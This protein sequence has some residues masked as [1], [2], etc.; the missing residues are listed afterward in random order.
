MFL[1]CCVAFYTVFCLQELLFLSFRR[2]WALRWS[3]LR[4]VDRL[5]HFACGIYCSVQMNTWHDFPLVLNR[6][7]LHGQKVYYYCDKP[8]SLSHIKVGLC[9]AY[10]STDVIRLVVPCLELMSPFYK[11]ITSYLI[12]PLFGQNSNSH[13][14]HLWKQENAKLSP[15][16]LNIRFRRTPTYDRQNRLRHKVIACSVS[17]RGKWS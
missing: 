17:S 3:T 6:T 8:Y 5:L 14:Y 15:C 1:I 12:L 4:L 11:R 2:P 10:V 7:D 13:C 16:I 9:W